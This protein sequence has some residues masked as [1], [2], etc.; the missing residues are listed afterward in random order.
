MKLNLSTLNEYKKSPCK[1]PIEIVD[2]EFDF[3]KDHIQELGS[4]F[5]ISPN[6]R[7]GYKHHTHSYNIN[8]RLVDEKSTN[9]AS[10]S[11]I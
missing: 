7:Q 2:H 8:P 11:R 6:R 4:F 5:S 9:L 1:N 10:I 3:Y